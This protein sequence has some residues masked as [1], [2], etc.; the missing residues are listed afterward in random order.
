MSA[1]R[2]R[3]SWADL[4]NKRDF[5]QE[6]VELVWSRPDV[7]EGASQPGLLCETDTEHSGVG[8]GGH[9]LNSPL[10]SATL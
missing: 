4:G 9:L 8:F 5:L 1:P 10:P 6:G 3:S 7:V 2:L